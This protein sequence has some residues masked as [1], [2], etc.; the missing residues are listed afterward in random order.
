MTRRYVVRIHFSRE[1]E[2]LKAASQREWIV[3]EEGTLSIPTFAYA[4]NK[5]IDMRFSTAEELNVK[6]LLRM[7][8]VEIIGTWEDS[9]LRRAEF[10]LTELGRRAI[11]DFEARTVRA[12]IVA[13][14][15]M[16]F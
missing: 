7:R 5:S 15:E 1:Y 2:V 12:M 10:Q 14:D 8:N 3:I 11:K 4:L 16:P 13:A 9:V 6:R